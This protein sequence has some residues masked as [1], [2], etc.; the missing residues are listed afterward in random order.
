MKNYAKIFATC[1]ILSSIISSPLQATNCPK[2]AIRQGNFFFSTEYPGWQSYDK[3][4]LN[5][6]MQS[7]RFGAII[8]SLQTKR[9]ACVYLTNNPKHPWFALVS[10]PLSG[11]IIPDIHLI[12]KQQQRVWQYNTKHQDL[13]CATAYSPKGSSCHYTIEDVIDIK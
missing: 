12:N 10:Q 5:T 2:S 4:P 11:L 8:Y 1:L 13:T 3:I 9:L 7:S 6:N